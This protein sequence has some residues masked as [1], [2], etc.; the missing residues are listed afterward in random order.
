VF[1]IP[2]ALLL[3]YQWAWT[4]PLLGVTIS[5]FAWGP[6]GIWWAWSIGSLASFVLGAVWFSLG[7]WREGVLDEGGP[8]PTAADD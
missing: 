8:S 3:A 6:T 5:G 4:V 2:I 7:R 1:R